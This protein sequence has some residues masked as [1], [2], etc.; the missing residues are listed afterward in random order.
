L[1]LTLIR[2]C[3]VSLMLIVLLPQVARLRAERKTLVVDPRFTHVVEM[4]RSGYFGWEDY[5]GP[6]V[7]AITTGGDY[8]LVANDFPGYLEAQVRS[9]CFVARLV[10]V[11]NCAF[12]GTG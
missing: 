11:S 7:D 3:G 8:Y 6:I 5:F 12:V 10:S 9:R 1:S 4:V 2:A